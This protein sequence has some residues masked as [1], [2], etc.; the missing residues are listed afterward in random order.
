MEHT[1]LTDLLMLALFR[2]LIVSD[3]PHDPA[4]QRSKV[5]TWAVVTGWLRG[6]AHILLSVENMA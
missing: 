2:E 3:A 1:N 6:R 5:Q 4:R